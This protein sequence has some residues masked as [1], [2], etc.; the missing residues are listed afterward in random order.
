MT[1]LFYD[2]LEPTRASGA[3]R[4]AWLT[5]A[6]FVAFPV[7]SFLLSLA[8]PLNLATFAMMGMVTAFAILLR[9]APPL[10]GAPVPLIFAFVLTG[11]LAS[12]VYHGNSAA[13]LSTSL[14][15]IAMAVSVLLVARRLIPTGEDPAA[16]FLHNMRSALLLFLLAGFATSAIAGAVAAGVANPLA[17]LLSPADGG[18]LRLLARLT[19]GHS[20]LIPAGFLVIV[21]ELRLPRGWLS[22]ASI[23]SCTALLV[24]SGTRVAAAYLGVAIAFA[25]IR[26][27]RL[28]V[29]FLR[30][31]LVGALLL[32]ASIVWGGQVDALRPV[33]DPIQSALPGLR[34][35]NSQSALGSGRDGLNEVLWRLAAEAP[36]FGVGYD[37]PSIATGQPGTAA[38]TNESFL[39]VLATRGWLVALPLILLFAAPLVARRKLDP[40]LIAI[41]AGTSL[42]IILNGNVE[43]LSSPAS[44]WLWL[45]ATIILCMPSR[46][47]KAS[48]HG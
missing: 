3:T 24:A 5:T 10:P 33:L 13:T 45:M 40:A 11:Y 37:H 25:S 27:L 8:I 14:S 35:V 30:V 1:T 2:A 26:A 20:L 6:T 18:R 17:S 4:A 15:V 38:A 23:V 9:P 41:A 34:L 48:A 21:A 29:P 12:L 44:V 16:E 39:R 28:P 42:D 46:D 31:A 7:G 19:D 22:A 36:V 32:A 43:R 47:A